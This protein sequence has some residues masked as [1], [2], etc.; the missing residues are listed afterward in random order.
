MIVDDLRAFVALIAHG[1]LGRAAVQMRLTQPAMSRRIQRLEAA[2]GGALLDRSVKPARVSALGR[3]VYERA[4]AVLDAVDGLGELMDES[5]EPAGVFRIGAAQS[6]S[7]STAVAAVTLLKRR[8]P[9]LRIEMRPDWSA[10][11]IGSVQQGRLDVAAIM[12]PPPA[13]PPEGIDAE[14]IGAHRMLIVAPRSYA[15]KGAVPLRGLA[16]HPWVLYPEGGCICRA[17]LQRAFEA[18]GLALDVAVGDHGA[19]RQLALVTAGAGLGFV[20]EIM[21]RRSRYR[22]KLRIVRTSDFDFEFATWVIRP[23]HLGMLAAPAR[24]FAEVVGA[25][26]GDARARRA[27]A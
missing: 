7:D 11:L 10:E 27:A 17:A 15:A 25:R 19:E 26:F 24:L 6:I 2:I 13:R 12:L 16:A 1:A 20:P 9:R 22:T 3:R 8:Y 18:R 5:V 4:K 14:R 23:P 21:F